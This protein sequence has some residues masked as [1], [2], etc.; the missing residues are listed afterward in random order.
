[1]GGFFYNL[2]RKAGPKVRRAKWIWHSMTGQET[3][4]IKIENQVGR[5]LAREIRNQAELE[6]DPRIEQIL[7]ETGFRLSKCVA[8]ESRTF[9]FEALSEGESNAFALPGGFIFVTRSII[10]L[11]QWDRDEAAFIIAHEMAH[12]IR[13]HAINRIMRDFAVSAASRVVPSRGAITGWIKKTGVKYLE[14]AYSQELEFQA[15]KLGVRLVEAAGFAPEASITLL[16][17]LSNLKSSENRIDIG[18]YF[19]T[20]PPFEDRIRNINEQLKTLKSDAK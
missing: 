8:N 12:V 15:D 4:T 7:S 2:G 17:R 11:C 1:M 14:S 19:S 18:N 9:S 16:R 6:K 20:H 13:K 3:D 5:D 10:E